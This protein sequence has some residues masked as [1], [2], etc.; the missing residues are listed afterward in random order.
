MFRESS[1]F[2]INRP[3]TA[4]PHRYYLSIAAIAYNEAAYLE[5]W[6]EFHLGIGVDHIFLYDNDSTDA[7]PD[8]TSPYESRRLVTRIRWPHWDASIKRKHCQ[9]TA[10]GHALVNAQEPSRWVAFFDIDEFLFSPAEPHFPTILRSY[11]D[12]PAI[13]AF[14]TIFGTSGQ[15]K[16]PSD[17]VIETFTKSVPFERARTIEEFLFFKS[18]VQPDQVVG[19]ISSHYFKTTAWPVLAFNEKRRPIRRVDP[20]VFS[21]EIIRLNHYYTKSLEEFYESKI[22]IHA[23]GWRKKAAA[24]FEKRLKLI[25]THTEDDFVLRDFARRHVD[26]RKATGQ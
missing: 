8:I 15:L 22:P 19:V 4:H 11:E 17:R 16:R 9:N 7:T 18:I 6:I 10:Y 20:T 1:K 25:E 2:V 12:L 21:N 5:E 26:G 23:H 3:A 14:W 24:F 13:A